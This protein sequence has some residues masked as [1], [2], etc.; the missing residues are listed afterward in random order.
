M[1]KKSKRKKRKKEWVKKAP[2]E[3]ISHGPLRIE[4]YGRF[5]RLLNISTPEEHAAF[6]KRSREVNKEIL[7]DLETEV[8]VL[9]DLV[10]EYDPVELMHRAAYM[11]LPLFMKYKSEYDFGPDE[12]YYLPTVEYLQYLIARTDMNEDA[13]ELTE[14]EWNDLWEQAIKVMKLTW[15]YIFTRKPLEEASSQIDELRFT[16]DMRRLM[17][18]VER[19]SYFLRDYLE[20]SLNP[21]EQWIEEIYGIGVEEIVEGLCK[22]DE[23]QKTGVLGRYRDVIE[24]QE[25][26]SQKLKQK[27]FRADPEAPPDEIERTKQALLSEEFSPLHNRIEEKMRLTFTPAI[28]EI[29][30]LTSLPKPILSL[31]SVKPAEA[32]LTTL[33]GPDY[34]DLSP[35][36]TS[37][38]HYKPFLEVNG[39][40]YSF[41]HSG[42]EDRIAEIIEAD[43]FH[44]RPNAITV[45][46]K[47]R[48]DLIETDSKDLLVS[49]IKPDFA[50]QNAFY[51]NPDDAGNLT[52][53]DI[54]LGVDDVLFLVEVKAGAF[55]DPASRGAP[56]SLAKE[57][58]DL[59]MEG[60]YQS[61]RAEKYIKSNEEVAFF[62]VTGKEVICRIKQSE[63]RRIFRVVITRE[64]LGWVGAKIATLSILDPNLS[65][66]FPWHVSIDDLRVVAELFRDSEIRFVHFLE[67]RLRAS[68][69]TVLS[70]N[71]EIEH[72]GLYNNLNYYHKLPA[73]GMD[74]MTFDASYMQDIDYYFSEKSVGGNP[75]VPTQDMPPKMMQFIGALRNSRLRGRF[76][77]GSI[78]LSM[79]DGGRSEF[80]GVLDALDTA[81]AERKQQ[82]IRMPFTDSSF[83][84]SITCADDNHWQEEL[85]HSAA[86][87]Q[88]SECGRWLVVQ[89]ANESPYKIARV[90][91]ISPG[92]F[93][94]EDLVS[95]KL[96]LEQKTK[97]TMASQKIGRNDPCPCGSG[98]KFKRCHGFSA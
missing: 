87:M 14:S 20:T 60:Q 48:S 62:N 66:A 78:L 55:S 92:S 13:A 67:Q 93:S 23:Y 15:S 24:L 90:E 9:Q 31:L 28:L 98:K 82:T 95:S 22:V 85:L 68:A 19:Y 57:L 33:T 81:R 79:D 64:A 40:F 25:V 35:L 36:S 65:E 27:G 18:R 73:K 1:G 61:E 58:S 56:K 17:V 42:F 3:V 75:E 94:E 49:L 7:N 32:V 86:Q 53:L 89:L 46:A 71:D 38:L 96:R 51:P 4:R 5:T 70:Q 69:E 52:E 91:A 44:K 77:V 84:L 50:F 72:I 74:R 8:L 88:Q 45:M 54:L 59:I 83:G 39:K 11:L 47:K 2:D 16:I 43:L 30:D 97:R 10:K 21:Y 34:D 29:T 80:Q 76:E 41:Y 12:S 37:V 26:L 63:Y 6:L